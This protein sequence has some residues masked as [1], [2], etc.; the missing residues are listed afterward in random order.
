MR[1]YSPD[2]PLRNIA[3]FISSHGLGH[4]ARTMA[5]M[6]AILKLTP[7]VHFQIF[8]ETP[9]WFFNFSA[10]ESFTYH[11]V[12]TD[13]GMVQKTPFHEDV[14]KTVTLLDSFMPFDAD[15]IETLATR[16]C[17]SGCELVIC[18]ISPLG[19]AA[20]KQ[21]EIPSI[22]VENFTWDWIYRHYDKLNKQAAHHI[23]YLQDLFDS[24]DYRIQ[25]DPV[26]N[27]TDQTF[28][29][30]PISRMPRKTVQQTRRQ[31]GI[32]AGQTVVL[33]TLGG[34]HSRIPFLEHLID[35]PDIC[36]VVPGGAGAKRWQNNLLLLPHHSD[37]YH[38]DLVHASDAVVGKA[39]YSTLAEVFAAD[40]PFGFIPRPDFPES[41]KLTRFIENKMRG[42]E[43]S[44]SDYATGNW[45]ADI[46]NILQV[47]EKKRIDA[48]GADV[49]AGFV[50]SLLDRYFQSGR[51]NFV[52][53]H[54]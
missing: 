21:T 23:D 8:T 38:P 22:L 12:Q 49:A 25:T 20:A 11:N 36:F 14:E 48:N 10:S 39:G 5:I 9:S 33:I 46:S 32:P 3:C 31:L 44:P 41:P 45:I 40:V 1:P 47:P 2:G 26:C 51:F 18:D 4:A 7:Q 13:I 30:P 27:P 35:Y 52:N 19:I 17:Q 28:S 15:N 42:Y 6:E 43:I 37:C 53:G 54:F 29:C 34:I 50:C 24:A 16:L